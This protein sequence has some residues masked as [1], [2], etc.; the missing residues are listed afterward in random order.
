MNRYP[1][2]RESVTPIHHYSI[3]FPR[4]TARATLTDHPDKIDSRAA[5][6]ALDI[7][8][9][10]KY[11]SRKKARP[12]IYIY[13]HARGRGFNRASVRYIAAARDLHKSLVQSAKLR[14]T[15]ATSRS[16]CTR[17]IRTVSTIDRVMGDAGYWIG[18]KRTNGFVYCTCNRLYKRVI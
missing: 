17:V 14:G 6:L 1:N 5:I 12:N 9:V 10:H 13:M 3:A 15:R 2:N 16:F 4:T 8:H 18:F 7:L 11:M